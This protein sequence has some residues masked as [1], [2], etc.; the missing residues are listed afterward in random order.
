MKAAWIPGGTS[1][2]SSSQ[3]HFECYF[4]AMYIGAWTRAPVQ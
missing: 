3:K 4:E 1:A 2:L